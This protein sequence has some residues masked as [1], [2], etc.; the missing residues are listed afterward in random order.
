[1]FDLDTPEAYEQLQRRLGVAADA[2]NNSI[3]A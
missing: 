2:F 3:S 1:V